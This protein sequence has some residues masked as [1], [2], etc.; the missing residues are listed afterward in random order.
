MRVVLDTNVV[1]SGVF[2]GGVP[3][4][5]LAAWSRGR[6][7]V[8]VSAT[9]LAEYHR[10]GEALA[11]GRPRLEAAW[12]PV[13]AWI[14]RHA[15]LV[16]ADATI[17]PVSADRDDDVFLACAFTGGAGYIVSGDRHLRDVSGWRGIS[18]LSPRRFFDEVLGSST[19][20][21]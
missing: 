5:V 17:E 3:G 4:E 6:F 20:I 1:L 12:R 15:D 21:G 10:A 11:S 2:F 13:M 14:A 16:V 7:E 8:V 19:A 9:I 18:V